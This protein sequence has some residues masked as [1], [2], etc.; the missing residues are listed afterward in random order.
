M[1]CPK[2]DKMEKINAEYGKF[3]TQQKWD[4]FIT[5]KSDYRIGIT[6]PYTWSKRLLKAPQIDNLFFVV[7]RDKGDMNSK[8][9]HML[10]NSSM[11]I[12]SELVKDYSGVAI[13][14]F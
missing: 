13:G 4:Y 9:V 6:T 3:L 5:C 12:T 7:E 11:N 2:T 10:L 8:H 14:D 1:L